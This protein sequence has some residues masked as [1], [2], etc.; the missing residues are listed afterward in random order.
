MKEFRARRYDSGEPVRIRI[1]RGILASLEPLW[2]RE[3]LDDWPWITPGF[4]D[5]QI[6]GFGGTWFGDESLT[7]EQVLTVLAGF[8][9]RGVTRLFPTLITNSHAALLH[10]FETIAAACEREQW[11]NAM[12]PGCHLEGPFISAE[13]G[14]RGAHPAAHVRP[15]DWTEFEKL[16]AASGR[17]IRLVTLAPECPGAIEFIRR[18]VASGVTVAVGHTAATGQQIQAA[19]DAGAKLSTHLG[20]G[21]HPVLKRHPNVIWDQLGDARLHASVISDGHHLP[22]S[23]LRSILATKSAERTIITCDASG[24]AG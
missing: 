20:N 8:R 18:A 12:V 6:N 17:R 19:I 21:A 9:E 10:G 2:T 1:E 3:P 13:D 15:C 11:A 4:F 22:A 14:P 24:L 23:V 5:L 16:N 7:V